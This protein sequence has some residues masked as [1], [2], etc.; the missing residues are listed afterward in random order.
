MSVYTLD[1][2]KADRV[3][4]SKSLDETSELT[5]E[6][7]EP[8]QHFTQPP[9]HFTEASLVKTLEEL[10]IGRPST[11]APTISNDPWQT[12]IMW[13]KE[14]KHLYVIRAWRGGQQHHEGSHSREMWM[15]TLHRSHGGTAGLKSRKAP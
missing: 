11:Y 8:K 6:E 3:F 9:A 12:V 4:L 2:E 7:I 1:E 5:K 10:G 14:Q 15:L 13:R